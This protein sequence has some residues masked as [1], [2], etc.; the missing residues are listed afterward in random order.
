MNG[1]MAAERQGPFTRIVSRPRIPP[2]TGHQTSRSIACRR[3]F[4]VFRQNPA[5]V[6]RQ[7]LWPRGCGGRSR[8]RHRWRSCRPLLCGRT[9]P[10]SI[11]A[12]TWQPIV[13]SCV[14]FPYRFLGSTFGPISFRNAALRFFAAL[15]FVIPVS[16]AMAQNLPGPP[17]WVCQVEQVCNGADTCIWLYAFP[18]SFKLTQVDADTR[19]YRVE[20]H[21]GY[22]GVALEL[23]S[24]Q[25]VAHF[26]ETYSVAN[27]PPPLILTRTNRIADAHGF[28]LRFL[29]RRES[30][31]LTIGEEKMLVSCS[32][33][34]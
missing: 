13:A 19:M 15:F 27:D 5:G 31:Q 18:M 17:P 1:R 10:A 12:T 34:R 3:A 26:A 25:D 20:S 29:S 28:W 9:G 30:R 21:E 11:P 23:P 8:L 4:R 16:A 14:V 6:R 7:S 2:I 32:S 24:L 33:V 22:K